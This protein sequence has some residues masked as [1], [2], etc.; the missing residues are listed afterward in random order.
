VTRE[1]REGSFGV[2]PGFPVHRDESGAI[3]P[4]AGDSGQGQREEVSEPF[5]GPS[6]DRMRLRPTQ[7][8]E[9]LDETP[10]RG[11]QGEGDNQTSE[12]LDKIV[13]QLGEMHSL[14]ENQERAIESLANT[15][16][17]IE[18]SVQN[19]LRAAPQ[20]GTVGP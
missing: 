17:G 12:K 18:S 16:E 15:V 14:M 7:E 3:V 10:G 9:N 13:A 19:I 8:P 11:V 1:S 20:W 4:G 6:A 5:G 2:V